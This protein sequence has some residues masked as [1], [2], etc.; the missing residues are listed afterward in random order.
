MGLGAI[1]VIG[2]EG[3]ASRST[4]PQEASALLS[5]PLAWFDVLGRS[6]A[7][8][9][10]ERFVRADV[11]VVSLLVQD[12]SCIIKPSFV[13]FKNVDLQIV[14]DVYAAI[15]QKLKDYSRDGIEHAFVASANAYAETD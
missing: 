10:I 5:Q 7:E 2:L 3:E 13:G 11:E 9:V 14:S 12:G 4:A 1:V 15:C 8:R 6:V